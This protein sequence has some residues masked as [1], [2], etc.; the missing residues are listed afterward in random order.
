MSK[1]RDIAAIGA[2][3]LILKQGPPALRLSTDYS[4]GEAI[5]VFG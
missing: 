3:D 2:K 1:R 5:W 4:R